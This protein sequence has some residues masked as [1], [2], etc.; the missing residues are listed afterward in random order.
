MTVEPTSTVTRVPEGFR[1]IGNV[2]KPDSVITLSHDAW[3]K[4]LTVRDEVDQ[5]FLN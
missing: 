4:L 2:V 3:S 5:C 1:V